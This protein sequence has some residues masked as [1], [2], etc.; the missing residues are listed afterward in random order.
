M[1]SSKIKSKVLAIMYGDSFVDVN[2]NSGKARLDIYHSVEQFDH[3]MLKKGIL[4]NI[5]GVV[6]RVVEKNDSRILLSG[7]TREGFRLQTNFTNYFFK[8]KHAPFKYVAKQIV[9]PEAL[10]ILW[11]DDGTLCIDRKNGNYSAA[12]L[13]TDS[14]EVWQVEEIRK[15]W[16]NLYGWTPALMDYKCRNKTYPRLRL[17]KT[18]AEK[19]SEIVW[20]HTTPSLRYKLLPCKTLETL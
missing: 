12:Y 5:T 6:T 10:A 4:D 15:A 8:L 20:E 9:K 7:K 2:T 11:A 14:M 13:C 3:L 16:N 18:Q 19:L 17:I 1:L